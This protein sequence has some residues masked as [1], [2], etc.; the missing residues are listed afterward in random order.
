M[1]WCDDLAG[2]KSPPINWQLPCIASGHPKLTRVELLNLCEKPG[3]SLRAQLHT[4]TVP[5]RNNKCGQQ[6]RLR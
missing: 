5:L 2:P 4:Y 1:D 6:L 3:T